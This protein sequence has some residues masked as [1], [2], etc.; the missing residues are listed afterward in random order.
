M[1]YGFRQV[2]AN[3]QLQN[4][5]LFSIAEWKS[6]IHYDRSDNDNGD[7]SRYIEERDTKIF[8]NFLFGGLYICF[9]CKLETQ[10]L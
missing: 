1:I 9:F 4:E 8:I 3:F 2:W 6:L 10:Y 7:H 5:S